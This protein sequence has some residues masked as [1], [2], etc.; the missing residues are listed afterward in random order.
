[1]KLTTGRG[2]SIKFNNA[3]S[4]PL[5]IIDFVH[6][7]HGQT[8]EKRDSEDAKSKTCLQIIVWKFI[9]FFFHHSYVKYTS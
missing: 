8:S 2:L 7:H 4:K 5:N 3:S 6:I 1:M 9:H